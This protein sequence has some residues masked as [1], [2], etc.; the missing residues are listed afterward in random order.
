MAPLAAPAALVAFSI[1]TSARGA[2]P[3]RP[4]TDNVTQHDA[5][6]S[7]I[8]QAESVT[9]LLR[10]P[11]TEWRGCARSTP[12]AAPPD[13]DTSTSAGG[14]DPTQAVE[15]KPGAN[16]AITQTQIKIEIEENA[17]PKTESEK[18]SPTGLTAID[19]CSGCGGIAVALR[20]LGFKILALVESDPRC[21]QTLE[22]NNFEGIMHAEIEKVDFTSFKNVSVLTGGAPCQP[23]SNAG[24]HHG[25]NDS[26]NLWT[27]VVRAVR[28]ARPQ[29]F[30][31]EMV[32]GFLTAKFTQLREQTIDLLSQEGYLVQ[33]HRS[34][35][36]DHGLAQNR[37]RCILTGH[38]SAGTIAPPI[39]LAKTTVLEALQGLPPLGSLPEHTEKGSPKCYQGHMPSNLHTQAHTVVAGCHGPGGGNNTVIDEN[40][41]LRYFTISELARLQGFPMNHKFDPVWSH[42]IKQLGNACPPPMAKRW[43]ERLM[44]KCDP[45]PEGPSIDLLPMDVKEPKPS[46]DDPDEIEPVLEINE[47]SEASEGNPDE[48]SQTAD[49]AISKEHQLLR[50]E[51]SRR[52]E[53]LRILNAQASVLYIEYCKGARQVYSK[54]GKLGMTSFAQE[55]QSAAEKIEQQLNP[56]RREAMV[57]SIHA[58]LPLL[59]PTPRKDK[60]LSEATKVAT[61]LAVDKSLEYAK[62]TDELRKEKAIC[63]ALCLDDL[64]RLHDSQEEQPPDELKESYFNMIDSELPSEVSCPKNAEGKT[65]L[66]FR[67]NR[68]L[69]SETETDDE[70]DFFHKDTIMAM[71]AELEVEGKYESIK[72]NVP[73]R[74]PETG[75]DTAIT[76]VVDSGATWC[77][78]KLSVIEKKLPHLLDMMQPSSMKF[79]D[80]SNNR[81]SLVGR[82][83]ITV[84]VGSRALKSY[85]YVFRELGADFLLGANTLKRHGCLIDCHRNRVYVHDDPE[86]GMPMLPLLCD[87]CEAD[88]C[89]ATT[90]PSESSTSW[91][92]AGKE[93]KCCDSH[94]RAMKLVCNKDSCRLEIE[95][96]PEY[97][98]CMK[99]TVAPGVKL[100]LQQDTW[101]QPGEPM[102]LD[103]KLVGLPLGV[104]HPL[105][106]ETCTSFIKESGLEAAEQTLQNPTNSR[107]PFRVSNPRSDRKPV[108]LRKGTVVARSFALKP[109]YQDTVLLAAILE[110]P[111]GPSED[112]PRD[113]A[114]GGI[115]DLERLGFSLKKA[116]DPDQRLEDGSYAPLADEKKLLLYEI[117]RRWHYVFSRDTKIPKVSFLVVME[118]PTGDAPPS[119]ASPISHP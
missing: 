43:L 105:T 74:N 86:L 62:L 66:Y 108:L 80:A 79:R 16:D 8:E 83:P 95:G 67:A 30:M 11:S 28:E 12:Q 45:R 110:D 47:A 119:A 20:E 100:V 17:V 101:V 23:F 33:L 25:E 77:A 89:T 71:E 116:I 32:D 92:S 4:P 31:F 18:A 13:R 113:L 52:M 90:D 46:A 44:E 26:R 2:A 63:H 118:I 78:L 103:P 104:L 70:V 24:L 73:F 19:I 15:K 68:S 94:G 9:G 54:G 64:S 35:A 112:K 53:L 56:A 61:R 85:S 91:T 84:M 5:S 3:T 69:L 38:R 10:D 1:A 109:D 51:I 22:A 65:K 97:L 37:R 42:A 34:N 21:I 39:V 49:P 93:P 102:D 117:A 98:E 59:S 111:Q 88:A 87:S 60:A 107:C 115:E 75:E 81:M 36:S 6:S 72:A 29:T 58:A 82:V 106:F 57:A 96:S 50:K 48:H 41:R 27:H 114:Q 7:D 55:L 14:G 40:G 99:E 76:S